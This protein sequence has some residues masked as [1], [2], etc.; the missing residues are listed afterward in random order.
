MISLIVLI[1]LLGLLVW[2]L[3]TF[4]P[5]PPAFKTAIVVIATV[6]LLLYL[7]QMFGLWNGSLSLPRR[8]R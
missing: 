3:T 2:A 7:L 4:I 5:M 8:V 1:A 6:F